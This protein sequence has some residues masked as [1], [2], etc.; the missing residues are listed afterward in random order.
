MDVLSQ[1][2]QSL[3]TLAASPGFTAAAVLTLALGLGANTAIFSVVQAV[4]LDPLPY[5]EADRLVMLFHSYPKL[6]L[7]RASVSAYGFRRYERE[8]KSFATMA[9]ATGWRAP[10]NLTGAGEPLRVRTLAVTAR[11]FDVLGERAAHG[12]TFVEGEDQPGREKV[13]V[14]AQGLFRDRFGAE[15]GV[16]GS[17]ISLDGEPYRVVGVMPAGFGDGQL[18][19]W[20]PL[21]F[22]PDILSIDELTSEFLTVI[23]RLAPGVSFEQAKAEMATISGQLLTEV[24][25]L[26]EPGWHVRLDPMAEIV[27]GDVKPALLVLLGAVGLVLAI[28]CANVANLLLARGASR[29]REI[30]VRA[31]LGAGRGRIVRQLLGESVLLALAGGALGL[32]V[33]FWGVRLLERGLPEHL[34]A[35]DVGIDLPVLGFALAI[36][37]ATGLLFGLA[38]AL[39]LSRPRLASELTGTRSSAGPRRHLLRAALVASEVAL[40]LTLLVCA[41]LLIRSFS[42]LQEVD[43]GFATD[44]VLTFR[45][46]LPEARYGE[47]HQILAFWDRLLERLGSLPGV[48]TA[49]AVSG[50]PLSGFL[51]T[52]SY[53]LEDRQTADGEPSPHGSPRVASPGYFAAMGIPLLQ[54]RLF[55]EADREEAPPVAL[56]DQSVARRY[57][58]DGGPHGSPIGKRLAFFFEGS[59]AEPRWREIVGIVGHVRNDTLGEESKGQIY[60][61][62]AQSPDRSLAIAIRIAGDP[63]AVTDEVRREVLALDPQQPIYEVRPIAELVAR[64]LAQARFSTSLFTLFAALAAV[65][66][67]V[68][69]YGVIAYSVAQRTQE[70]GIRMALGADRERVV[71]LVVR[72]GALLAGIGLAAGLVLSLLATRLLGSLLY[73]VS[74]TDPLT[75]AAV[76]VLL[77]AVALA[78]SWLPARRAT[79]V[80]P[81]RALRSEG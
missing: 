20:I 63:A 44:G 6:D 36:S 66:A 42:R 78:A 50:L 16:V 33:A 67:V 25:D 74:A 32:V 27:V 15:P 75:F 8:A 54:G 59:D 18:D 51:G 58:P 14:L 64:S 13:V 70:I 12:R 26:R 52:A 57:W 29:Q 60:M 4:L 56:I 9:A 46:A 21:A 2:R 11:Y 80:D 24:P 3:R 35:V 45:V 38:P 10:Q 71:G 30:A 79:R 81:V 49:G 48:Q 76:P 41:G 19:V 40:S 43:P 22:P 34:A 39:Q 65:L 17:K 69:I 37:V 5:R 77:A 61:P 72:Q 55:T 31:A 53:T 23:A 47:D 62:L 1:L 28:A 68:G 7:E 73:E